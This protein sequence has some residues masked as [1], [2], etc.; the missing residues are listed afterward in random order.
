MG[1]SRFLT[2]MLQIERDRKKQWGQSLNFTLKYV[3]ISF[4]LLKTENTVT[5]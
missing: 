4:I 2:A 1:A 3:W 5:K